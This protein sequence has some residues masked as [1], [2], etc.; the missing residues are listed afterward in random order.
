VAQRHIG[1]KRTGEVQPASGPERAFGQALRQLRQKRK[2]PQDELAFQC[3]FDR[4]YIS[5]LERGIRSPTLRTIVKL[6]GQLQVRP[7]VLIR[8]VEKILDQE[9]RQ[10]SSE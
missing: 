9:Q 6:C 8:Q 10:G 7:S 2:V 4:T 5:L 3:G 1:G